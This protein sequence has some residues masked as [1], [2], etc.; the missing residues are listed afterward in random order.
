MQF[1]YYD[2]AGRTND[3]AR[4]YVSP[5][6]LPGLNSVHTN[7]GGW[8]GGYGENEDSLPAPDVVIVGQYFGTEECRRRAERN[9]T[10]VERIRF[11]LPC[12][13]VG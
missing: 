12:S 1:G 3:K 13:L 8:N 6:V 4:Q 9:V 7:Q 2:A 11:G 5:E 10:A